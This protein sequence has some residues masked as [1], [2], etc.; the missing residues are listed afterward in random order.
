MVH[1]GILCLPLAGHLNP[2]TTLGHEL[3][4]RGHR[5]TV[6]GLLDI[7]PNVVS[8]GLSFWTLGETDY[9]L[10]SLKKSLRNLGELYGGAALKYTTNLCKEGATVILRDAPKA[11]KE[12]GVEI[13]LIDQSVLEGQTIAQHLDIPFITICN[14]LILNSE[15]GVPLGFFFWQYNSSWWGHLR[16]RIGRYVFLPMLLGRPGLSL[17][18]LIQ[19]HRDQWNLPVY[20]AS[21]DNPWSQLAQIS[22]QPSEFEFYRHRLPKYFHFTGPY[23]NP[24]SR[25]SVVDFPYER[26]TGK[27]LIYASLGTLQNRLRGVFYDIAE[28]C[29]GMNIQLVI[30]LGGTVNQEFLSKLPG[31]PLVVEYAPQLELLQKAS[32]TITHGGLNTTLESLRNGIP[33]VVIPITNDQPGVAARIAKTGTGEVVRLSRLGRV[34][35]PKLRAAIQQV[36]TENSYREKAS[37]LQEAIR[38]A[39]GVS[40]AADIVEQVVYTGKPV[41]PDAPPNFIEG[42]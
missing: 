41:F 13:L 20:S 23:S 8:A 35:V 19:N 5:V 40:H 29:V 3:Q 39:G 10:G 31:D 22:Q 38:Q 21:D 42:I 2:M 34:N 6:F 16:N 1:F 9:P 37:R 4:R 7:Q 26:L 36:L 11:I 24:A 27:P 12:A 32:L 25:K 17:I 15:P 30:S 18:R 33:L 28:A 14:A